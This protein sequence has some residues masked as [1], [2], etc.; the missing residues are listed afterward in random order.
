MSTTEESQQKISKYWMH[1]CKRKQS[2]GCNENL[3][4]VLKLIDKQRLP[5]QDKHIRNNFV[6]HE[7]S[8]SNVIEFK[9]HQVN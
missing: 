6:V 9:H 3:I 2:N 8:S 1:L 4:I 5:I 7:N